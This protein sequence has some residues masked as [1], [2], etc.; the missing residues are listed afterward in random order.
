MAIRPSIDF[1]GEATSNIIVGNTVLYGATSGEAFFRGVA[2]GARGPAFGATAVVEGTGDHGC[3]YM[4]GGGGG[5]RQTGRNFAAGRRRHRL[6]VRRGGQFASLQ[7]D[8]VLARAGGDRREREK[9]VERA[10][11]H[12]EQ[13]KGLLKALVADHKWTGACV[14]ILDHWGEA[15]KFVR[16]SR[17]IQAGARRDQPEGDDRA[18]RDPRR[19]G[20]RGRDRQG[21]GRRPEDDQGQR[22][23]V[24]GVRRRMRGVP[25]WAM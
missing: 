12:R 8:D 9:S 18:R 6:R 23:E 5:A 14:Q 3:E 11:W 17:T 25:Q 19:L 16:C 2:G 15:R 7:L 21:Q 1:R 20:R 24:S 4:T 10:I 22:A 13:A